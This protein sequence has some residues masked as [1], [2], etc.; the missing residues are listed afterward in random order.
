MAIP[1]LF[2]NRN[3]ELLDPTLGVSLIE[4]KFLASGFAVALGQ[5]TFAA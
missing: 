4:V 2:S 3:G 5:Q 1:A